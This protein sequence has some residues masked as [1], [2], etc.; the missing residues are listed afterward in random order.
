M[1]SN[2][3]F[4]LNVLIQTGFSALT[5]NQEEKVVSQ[6]WHRTQG[7]IYYDKANFYRDHLDCLGTILS[8]RFILTAATCIYN[9]DDHLKNAITYHD[10][11][12]YGIEKYTIPGNFDGDFSLFPDLAV[13]KLTKDM[14]LNKWIVL[15]NKLIDYYP[16]DK[17]EGM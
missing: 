8:R 11:K 9:S 15:K 7:F 4:I 12:S 2:I 17:T 10:K 1:L 5:I 14:K 16:Q 3:V 6:N 13:L